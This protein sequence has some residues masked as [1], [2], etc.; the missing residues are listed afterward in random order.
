VH[1]VISLPVSH[2]TT[3]THMASSCVV[4]TDRA[5]HRPLTCKASN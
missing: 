2:A 5:A 3:T 4:L 1:T